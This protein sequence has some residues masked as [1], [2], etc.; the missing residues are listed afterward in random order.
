ME[1]LHDLLLHLLALPVDPR[2]LL[3]ALTHRRR[4]EALASRALRLRLRLRERVRLFLPNDTVA[5][6]GQQNSCLLK[7][8]ANGGDARRKLLLGDLACHVAI[9]FPCRRMIARIDAPAGKHHGAAG[10]GD[11]G[12][13]RHHQGFKL[14]LVTQENNR[15]GGDRLSHRKARPCVSYLDGRFWRR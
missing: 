15:C 9:I 3:G 5:A 13:S 7:R 14:R 11:I 10:E 12:V 4:L 6:P 2:L 1:Q 8:L